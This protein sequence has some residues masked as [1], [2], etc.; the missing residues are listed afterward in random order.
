M[1]EW[2]DYRVFD[3]NSRDALDVND[4]ANSEYLHMNEQEGL[5]RRQVI[6]MSIV[7]GG[8]VLFRGV[9]AAEAVRR[10]PTQVL[11]PYYPVAKPTDQDAD[12]TMIAGKD[13][14]AAGQVIHV[15]GRLTNRHGQP[16]QGA[17]IEIWQANTH[18]RY[19]HASDRN[20]RPL[21]PN[22]EG[23]ALLTSDAEGHYRFKT[24]KPGGYPEES[25]VMR[26]PHIHFD[27][28]GK[29]NRLVTQMYFEGEP[30]NDGDRH[31][32]TA[33]ANKHRLIVG[34]QRSSAELEPNSL[35]AVWDIVL[36]EG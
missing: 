17:R 4:G 21:D 7:A 14:H 1:H 5:S 18:G 30:L 13:G 24:I 6:G 12:M 19:A 16:V 27:V 33:H 35:R 25:G 15:M 32:Q 22:F 9:A 23:Y 36:D 20:S 31:L 8:A 28:T 29:A 3:L 11:G 2:Q 26:A 10:T 34:Q